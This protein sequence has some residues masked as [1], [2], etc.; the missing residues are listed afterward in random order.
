MSE[1]SSIK[2]AAFLLLIMISACNHKEESHRRNKV[3]LPNQKNNRVNEK[4]FTINSRTFNVLDY[5]VM[6][7]DKTDNTEAFS[8]CMKAVIEAGGG[9]MYIP[10][11][12]YRGRIIIPGTKKWITV[13]IVGES[14]PTPIF[15]TIGSFPV[16]NKG[17][18]IKSH[19][20]SSP[21]THLRS[22]TCNSPGSTWFS[23]IW[24]SEPM[25]ILVSAAST[26]R[27]RRNAK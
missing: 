21:A 15:G 5:G 10:D 13:E 24:M 26:W 8:A 22:F 2:L 4:T 3:E 12:V 1:F 23:G 11:G 17:T 20:E 7:D 6:G 16:Q 14:E 19:A 9:R 27:T 25:I 18:I